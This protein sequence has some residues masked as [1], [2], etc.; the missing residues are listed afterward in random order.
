MAISFDQ[1]NVFIRQLIRDQLYSSYVQV[2]PLLNVLAG[3]SVTGRD[4]LGDPQAPVIWGGAG[5]GRATLRRQSGSYQHEF[6]YQDAETDASAAVGLDGTTPV[7]TVYGD[8]LVKKAAI[9]WTDFWAPLRIRKDRLDGAKSN[10]AVGSLMEDTVAMG[11]NKTLE[12]H[13]SELWTGTLTEAQQDAEVWATYLGVQHSCDGSG[14]DFYGGQ[15]R[16]V[17]TALQGKEYAATA[18]AT[19]GAITASTTIPLLRMVRWMKTENTTGGLCNRW[20]GAGSLAITTGSLWNVMANEAEGQHTI[21]DR[22]QE[23]PGLQMARGSKFPVIVKDGTYITYD[24]DCPSGEFYLLTPEYWVYEVEA[25]NN[26]LIE[27][28]QK[29]WLNDEGG[30]K[31]YYTQIH[32]KPRLTCYRPDLNVKITGLT[33]T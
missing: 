3:S 26:F 9:R 27:E 6:K 30:S 29:K 14:S 20:A 31:Y 33:V 12:K 5:I 19:A 10:L 13:Q 1:A 24:P 8:D 23:V 7:A 11:F 21:Y 22:G 17:H 15:D 28:W 18:L 16:A 32:A 25:G 2:K 4:S